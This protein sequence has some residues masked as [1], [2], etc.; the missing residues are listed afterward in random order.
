ME[1]VVRTSSATQRTFPAVATVVFGPFTVPGPV[2][3]TFPV[4]KGA[5]AQDGVAA[6][7]YALKRTNQSYVAVVAAMYPSGSV[8][9]AVS[10]KATPGYAVASAE[11]DTC[12][13]RDTYTIA[14]VSALFVVKPEM[15]ASPPWV[16]TMTYQ[17]GVSAAFVPENVNVDDGDVVAV[18]T[19]PVYPDRAVV[20]VGFV[21]NGPYRRCVTVVLSATKPACAANVP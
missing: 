17:P 7:P 21:E 5:T 14:V 8:I 2:T 11:V 1:T 9:V 10:L 3:A 12:G 6:G 20:D 16:D 19:V 15:R 13:F 18:V 4:K